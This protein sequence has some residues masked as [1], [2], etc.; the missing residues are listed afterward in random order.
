MLSRACA[1]LSDADDLRRILSSPTDRLS[2]IRAALDP[3]KTQP[4][5][6]GFVPRTAP[7]RGRTANLSQFLF[8]RD[9]Y[10]EPLAEL[11]WNSCRHPV[12]QRIYFGR[13]VGSPPG[14][15][16]GGITGIG[17]AWGVGAL[18]FGSTLGGHRTPSVCSSF[19]LKV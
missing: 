7:L 1:S 16:G 15:P 13:T 3:P 6:F 18:M 14:L 12:R 11:D 4:A 2:K 17:P 19:S 8:N 5:G 9:T 10:P